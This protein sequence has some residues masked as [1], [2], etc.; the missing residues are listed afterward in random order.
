MGPVLI[1]SLP[2]VAVMPVLW[3]LS[4][5]TVSLPMT[6]NDTDDGH[7]TTDDDAIVAMPALN[8]TV[9]LNVSI[10]CGWQ[11]DHLMANCLI[12]FHHVDLVRA[13]HVIPENN[14]QNPKI[15]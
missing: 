5:M 3:I 9:I 8:P 2:V 4:M 10:V 1:V 7:L 14:K 13:H 11:I 15:I 12:Q 6:V